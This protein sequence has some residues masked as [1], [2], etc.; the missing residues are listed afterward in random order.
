MSTEIYCT[1]FQNAELSSIP[2][3]TLAFAFSD[4]TAINLHGDTP[5]SLPPC[6]FYESLSFSATEPG[7][8]GFVVSR[9]SKDSALY[10]ALL[11]VLR[12]E[13]VV[14]YAPGSTPV[15]G[16]PATVAHLPPDMLSGLGQP[17]LARTPE[18]L[19][20]ELFAH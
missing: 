8:S 15:V 20:A 19:A 17:V 12:L 3:Q 7:A 11:Q 5:A 4:I 2:R 1:R 10:E 9:P 16:N 14:A 6:G 13:G 18:Q